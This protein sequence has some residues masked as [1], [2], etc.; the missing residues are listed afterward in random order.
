MSLEYSTYHLF[1]K[2]L[3]HLLS[4]LR[5]QGV[6]RRKNYSL[7]SPFP[8]N[9]QRKQLTL[10]VPRFSTLCHLQLTLIHIDTKQVTKVQISPMEI[11]QVLLS[12][13]ICYAS[14]STIIGVQ[15]TTELYG[16][17]GTFLPERITTSTTQTCVSIVL[18][19]ENTILDSST[20]SVSK[21][22][23]FLCPGKVRFMIR[24]LLYVLNV[25][26]STYIRNKEN[27][28]LYIKY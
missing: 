26:K 14:L 12:T 2:T 28:L 24:N 22:E 15:K 11:V 10:C 9:S 3:C 1:R 4:V 19:L 27:I 8:P 17:S 7:R 20:I 16:S 5:Y 6:L 21:P 23:L 18:C 25:V 13:P